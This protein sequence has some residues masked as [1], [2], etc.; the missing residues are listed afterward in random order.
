MTFD[1]KA[2]IQNNLFILYFASTKLLIIDTAFDSEC[3]PLQFLVGESSPYVQPFNI[4]VF[5]NVFCRFFHST[6]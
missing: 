6:K 3:G 2:I 4:H 5:Y 1:V